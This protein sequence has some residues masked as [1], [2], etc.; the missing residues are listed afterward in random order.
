MAKDRIVA[1][2]F[3]LQSLKLYLLYDRNPPQGNV[4]HIKQNAAEMNGIAL[5]TILLRLYYDSNWI[6]IIN[7]FHSLL[8]SEEIRKIALI[9]S[10][11]SLGIRLSVILFIH[12]FI[13][14]TICIIDNKCI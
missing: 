11:N 4:T 14:F 2:V 5:L 12:S 7:M 1:S 3:L 8:H 6:V 9:S 13:H 10:P